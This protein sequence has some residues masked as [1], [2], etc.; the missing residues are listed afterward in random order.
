MWLIVFVIYPRGWV[1]TLQFC[2]AVWTDAAKA[3][4]ITDRELACASER[5]ECKQIGAG[6]HLGQWSVHRCLLGKQRLDVQPRF[7]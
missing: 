7:K 1:C 4:V 5:S 3:G 6:G 2:Q